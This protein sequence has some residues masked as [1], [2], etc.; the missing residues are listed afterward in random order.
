MRN[1]L[2]CAIAHKLRY[3]LKLTLFRASADEDD[4]DL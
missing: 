1:L 4:D 3:Q 2:A